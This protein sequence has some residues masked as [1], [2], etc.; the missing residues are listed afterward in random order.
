MNE[1]IVLTD[2]EIKQITGYVQPS[3]QQRWLIQNLGVS[4]ERRADGSLSV[5]RRAYYQK[6]GIK[7]ERRPELR[8]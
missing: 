7:I 4:A 2:D 8:I 3:A 6:R 1:P 5:D